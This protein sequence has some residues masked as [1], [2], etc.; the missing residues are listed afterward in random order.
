MNKSITKK[1]FLSITVLIFCTT[2]NF[3][4][5]QNLKTFNGNF[6]DGKAT[7]TYYMDDYGN[8]VPHGSFSYTEILKIEQA[9]ASVKIS[10][11]FTNGKRN[12]K[13]VFEAIGKGS[14][15]KNVLGTYTRYNMNI[16]QTIRINYNNGIFDG[17]FYYRLLQKDNIPDLGQYGYY[18]SDITCQFNFSN[19]ALEGKFFIIDK[20]EKEPQN[21]SGMVRNGFFDGLITDDGKE[22]NFIK[23]ILT[24]NQNWTKEEQDELKQDVLAFQPYFNSNEQDREAQNFVLTMNCDSYPSTLIAKY[25]GK[26]YDNSDWLHDDIG[27][28]EGYQS[29]GCFYM[30]EN[31]NNREDFTKSSD[32]EKLMTAQKQGDVFEFIRAYQN[33][34]QS[35]NNYKPSSLIEV[36]AIYDSNIRQVENELKSNEAQ[37]ARLNQ[38]LEKYKLFV[39]TTYTNE[40][41]NKRVELERTRTDFYLKAANGSKMGFCEYDRKG[42]FTP[43]RC[44][45]HLAVYDFK[46]QLDDLQII[47]FT[48][49][50]DQKVYQVIAKQNISKIDQLEQDILDLEKVYL[51]LINMEERLL[52]EIAKLEEN[53]KKNTFEKTIAEK[54]EEKLRA[55]ITLVHEG[56]IDSDHYKADLSEI[57]SFLQA[58]LALNEKINALTEKSSVIE[59]EI[60]LSRNSIESAVI[61]S[62]QTEF[63]QGLSMLDD[64]R[65]SCFNKSLVE[66]KQSLTAIEQFE[67]QLN[68]NLSLLQ[69]TKKSNDDFTNANKQFELISFVDK[70]I[71]KIVKEI[72]ESKTELI[73]NNYLSNKSIGTDSQ[74]VFQS[75]NKFETVIQDHLKLLQALEGLKGKSLTKDQVKNLNSLKKD[76][77]ALLEALLK[78]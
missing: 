52:K 62:I 6:A 27:G 54:C 5:A 1:Y 43:A 47:D 64:L 74:T 15:Q 66:L 41:E 33:A 44:F 13:W 42:F 48:N 57:S 68:N 20:D 17:E 19:G 55:I 56:K 36:K 50:N 25:I 38:L 37:V 76:E 18:N 63:Q 70:N 78:I 12:G 30:I 75:A 11:N 22:I 29:V 60:K 77:A 2:V 58:G 73:N 61:A 39:K 9:T 16:S 10:G 7:Y 53:F 69:R 21:M 26:F 51:E 8:Q 65:V 59:Q 23:G 4:Y 32:F 46:T 31:L 71:A 3:F 34:A 40:V 45:L 67:Q 35:F 24:K 14:Y 49:P 72:F 28:D